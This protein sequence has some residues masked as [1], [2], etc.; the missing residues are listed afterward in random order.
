[1]MLR[2]T[3][4][5]IT[6]AACGMDNQL[7]AQEELLLS[8]VG[9]EEEIFVDHDLGERGAAPE[10]DTPELFRECDTEGFY[11]QLFQRYDENDSKVL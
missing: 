10:S 9:G 8:S 5:L 3:P 2:Y 6:L 1:M 11:N 4:L 7:T